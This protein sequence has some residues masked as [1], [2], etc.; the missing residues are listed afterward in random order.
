L[1]GFSSKGQVSGVAVLLLL[2]FLG[3]TED[4]GS[5]VAWRFNHRTE[6][7]IRFEAGLSLAEICYRVD[8]MPRRA[9]AVRRRP[10]RRQR[11]LSQSVFREASL[12]STHQSE[13]R[14]LFS[15]GKALRDTQV[16]AFRVGL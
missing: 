10:S 15:Q 5:C 16:C 9:H 11:L 14:Y 8:R 1:I 2:S 4:S 12:V 3:N 7:L 13:G 6:N